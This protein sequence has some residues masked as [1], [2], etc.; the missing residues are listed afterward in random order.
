ME[1]HSGLQVQILARYR[2]SCGTELAVFVRFYSTDEQALEGL[3][4][5]VNSFLAG[6]EFPVNESQVKVLMRLK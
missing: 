6:P 2:S 3:E 4:L 1:I 5:P